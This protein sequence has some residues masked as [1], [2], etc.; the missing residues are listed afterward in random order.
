MSCKPT[1]KGVRYNSLE[2]LYRANGVNPQQ[3]QQAQQ[4]YS[5]YLESLSKPNTNPILK[6]NQQEQV[7]KFTEL[8]ERLNN[9]EFLEGAKN[10]YENSEE[11]KSF[12]TQEEYNDYI[13][14]V[15]LGII[16]NPTSG[17]YN[18][19][20]KAKDVVYHGGKTNKEPFKRFV[21]KI[22]YKDNYFPDVTIE[23]YKKLADLYN[24]IGSNYDLSK[25]ELSVWNKLNEIFVV[26]ELNEDE[27]NI[28]SFEDVVSI[29]KNNGYRYVI[30]HTT[31]YKH[32]E[33][34]NEE[35]D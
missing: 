32:R 1:Y 15:S 16:K 5:Q 21:D 26:K 13:A 10:A 3:K 20:S 30:F 25:E 29:K 2:E 12:G 9:K 27:D 19:T 24:T 31:K 18:Y 23:V 28:A 6:D 8:Q 33:D 11:L 7:K 4:L 34:N 35:L 22:E 14:R 17:D